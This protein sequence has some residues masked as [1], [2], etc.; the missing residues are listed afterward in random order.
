MITFTGMNVNNKTDEIAALRQQIE[1]VKNKL[2][3]EKPE[4][5]EKPVTLG[6]RVDQTITSAKNFANEHPIITQA[7][8][9]AT[10]MAVGYGLAR[11]GDGIIEGANNARTWVH[12]Q[13]GK[14]MGG[15]VGAV[16]GVKLAS[17]YVFPTLAP[18]IGGVGGFAASLAT[19]ILTTAIMAKIGKKIGESV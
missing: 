16:T 3:E 17:S 4:E 10:S 12:G 14:V 11:K 15:V 5:S 8:V 2:G 13:A 6:D 1:E 7:G 18:S 19:V 9:F